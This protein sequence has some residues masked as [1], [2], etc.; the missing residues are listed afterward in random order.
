[1]L[2]PVNVNNRNTS[3]ATTVPDTLADPELRS[4]QAMRKDSS[5][6]FKEKLQAIESFGTTREFRPL[7]LSW[8]N[9]QN[10]LHDTALTGTA[11]EKTVVAMLR[12]GELGFSAREYLVDMLNKA[13][14]KTSDERHQIIS[15]TF[16]RLADFVDKFDKAVYALPQSL[17]LSIRQSLAQSSELIDTLWGCAQKGRLKIANDF[18]YEILRYT[19]QH[20]EYASNTSIYTATDR[21][22]GWGNDYV[23]RLTKAL[24]WASSLHEA[25]LAIEKRGLPDHWKRTNGND[26]GLYSQWPTHSKNAQVSSW[27]RTSRN[28]KEALIIVGDVNSGQDPKSFMKDGQQLAAMIRQ[29]YGIEPRI[30]YSPS[31]EQVNR[32][33]QQMA[34]SLKGDLTSQSLV[35]LLGHGSAGSLKGKTSSTPE[36]DPSF[37]SQQERNLSESML[38]ALV[39][40]TLAPA[41]KYVNLVIDC[42]YAGYWK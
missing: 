12:R 37:M 20:T 8:N 7:I 32:T 21:N 22:Y 19:G 41:S 10:A 17:R 15:A 2:G 27:N 14:L 29:R 23:S 39:N 40:H 38:R 25:H 5:F 6:G 3:R 9:L 1:M 34:I 33:L 42:C 16:S 11:K 18:F 36:R 24:S 26:D 31:I 13:E 30:L 4:L 28:R 35:Y